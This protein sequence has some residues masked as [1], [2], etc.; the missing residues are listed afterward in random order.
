MTAGET[1]AKAALRRVKC[2]PVFSTESDMTTPIDLAKLKVLPL[3]QR[4]SQA[5]LEDILVDPDSRPKRCPPADLA[6]I[7]QCARQISQ[8]RKKNASVMLIFGAHLIKNGAAAIVR[9]FLERDW[10]THLATNG[11]GA[12]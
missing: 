4:R 6:V 5:R 10:V 12:I 1:F 7:R 2:L 3:S 9:R 11:A 8:A